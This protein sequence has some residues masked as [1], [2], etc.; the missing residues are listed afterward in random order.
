MTFKSYPE[1]ELVSDPDSSAMSIK[2]A[3]GNT[4][5]IDSNC[6]TAALERLV[7]CWNACRHLYSPSAHIEATDEYVKRL[8][9]L[10]KDAVARVTELEAAQ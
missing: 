3:R 4:L 10:R 1:V 8:E 6:D 2:D 9:G 5:V 7:E